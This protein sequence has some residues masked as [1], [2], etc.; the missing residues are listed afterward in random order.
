MIQLMIIRHRQCYKYHLHCSL[1]NL[2]SKKT[3][4]ELNELG[5]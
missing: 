3:K 1:F 5:I 2:G 4:N